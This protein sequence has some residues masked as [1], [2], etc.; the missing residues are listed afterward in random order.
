MQKKINS[1]HEALCRE[2]AYENMIHKLYNN[3]ED[4]FVRNLW[5]KVVCSSYALLAMLSNVIDK[6]QNN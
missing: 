2:S 1:S 4:T 5:F 6:L 3:C